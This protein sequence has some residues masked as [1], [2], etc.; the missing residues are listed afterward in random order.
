MTPPRS[1]RPRIAPQ[2]SLAVSVK[3][4]AAFAGVGES[5]LRPRAGRSGRQRTRR[6]GPGPAPPDS[7]RRAAG[8]G[9]S[10]A[11]THLWW[12]DRDLFPGRLAIR[13]VLPA[14]LRIGAHIGYAVHPQHRCRGHATAML[15]AALPVT[16]E[17]GSE[18]VLL[19]CAGP[20]R[21]PRGG[22]A[23]RA[24]RLRRHGLGEARIGGPG[25][26]RRPAGAHG[27]RPAETVVR[28]GAGRQR[29]RRDHRA[30]RRHR[31]AARGLAGG[32]STPVVPAG[33]PRSLAA[34][35]NGPSRAGGG[36]SR[37]CTKALTSTSAA[38]H[39]AP[40][41]SSSVPRP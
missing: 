12:V 23:G 11:T 39:C 32:P 30:R 27:P 40:G 24:G 28:R 35:R 16:A 21:R 10:R 18:S 36:C 31:C 34:R 9:R 13:H 41:R 25:R 20:G 17:L 22:P 5:G 14:Q 15:G 4:A 38:S 2:L 33:P 8:A 37:P 29:G 1:E 26:P 19:T 3:A 7:T 6:A